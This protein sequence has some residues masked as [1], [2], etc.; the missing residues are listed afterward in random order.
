MKSR[1]VLPVLVISLILLYLSVTP[2]TYAQQIIVIT[3]WDRNPLMGE[4]VKRFNAKMAKEGKNIRARFTLIPYAEQ[5]ERFMTALAAGTAPDVEGIDLVL[6]PYFAS[7]GAFEDITDKYQALP[8][9]DK[10]AKAMLR[11]GIWNGKVYAL[12]FANDNSALI[13]NVDLFKK[14]GITKPPETWEELL[15][16]AI[17]LTNKT[18]GR[19]GIVFAG[20][21]PGMTM[22]TWL[23]FVWGAGGKLIS[24]D[25][26]RCMLCEGTAALR[27]LKLWVELAK[28]A[29]PPGCAT[30]KY[31]DYYNAFITGKAA[32]II[33][34]NWHLITIPHD[35]PTLNFSVAPIPRPANG[36]HSSF[37]G[38]DL[39]GI[40]KQSKHKEEA[41][42][43]IKFVHS[44]EAQVEV[45][46]KHGVIPVREDFWNNI[47]F[48]KDP[49][50]LIFTYGLKVGRCPKTPK[51]NLLYTPMSTM[52]Q[53]ALSGKWTP[54]QALKWVC[55]QINRILAEP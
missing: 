41:W 39:I 10:L 31:P 22:F 43:F 47:Y 40:T 5:A 28:K 4:I 32:M 16:D 54:E 55:E 42:E 34:G 21:D 8:Y 53:N 18:E 23:P 7:I 35:A 11:L 12:P 36:T 1:V 50:W 46:A 3:V 27:A 48:K 9:K 30:Y 6:V 33:G 29:A 2:L 24:D 15:E 52:M 13:Y 14:A 25:G 26:K 49:R 51:Y 37:V 19:Y 17:K 38:G 20:A 45:L 44:K